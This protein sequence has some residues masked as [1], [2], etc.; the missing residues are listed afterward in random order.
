MSFSDAT[1][2]A[3]ETVP[4]PD[5][6][7]LR[8]LEPRCGLCA[9][10]R[11]HPEALHALH[12]WAR[13]QLGGP[14][15]LSDRLYREFQV[16]V[17]PHSVDLHLRKHVRSGLI[18]DVRPNETRGGLNAE[19]YSQNTASLT[20]QF[21][22]LAS[23]IESWI[24]EVEDV[25]LVDEEVLSSPPGPGEEGRPRTRKRVNTEAVMARKH[26]ADQLRQALKSAHDIQTSHALIEIIVRSTVQQSVEQTIHAMR[27]FLDHARLQASDGLTAIEQ[28]AQT[29]AAAAFNDIMVRFRLASKN[30]LRVAEAQASL[31]PGEVEAKR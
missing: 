5:F 22:D 13:T 21:G 16:S 29:A 23:K 3:T 2:R 31:E 7:E 6:P 24:A 9:L 10:T 17:F 11:I 30:P 18:V 1:I 14:R 27:P 8:A 4:P 12:T 19:T 28:A 15:S 20:A 26:L 25:P